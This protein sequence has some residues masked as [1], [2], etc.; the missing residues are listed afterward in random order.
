M[1]T[2]LPMITA[3]RISIRMGKGANSNAACC[4]SAE[5]ISCL[6]AACLLIPDATTTHDHKRL[7]QTGPLSRYVLI[8]GLT[9]QMGT[10]HRCSTYSESVL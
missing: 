6:R 1:D 10:S 7:Y 5:I 2:V 4:L 3:A 9:S 8:N